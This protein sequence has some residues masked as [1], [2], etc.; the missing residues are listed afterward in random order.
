MVVAELFY[1]AEKSQRRDENLMRCKDFVS[2]FEVID[3]NLS[4]AEHYADIRATLE[5]LGMSIGGN[6]MV[7]ASVVRA[8]SGVLVTNNTR[9]FERV[10]SLLLEDW[11]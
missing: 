8:N 10:D 2:L 7:I 4:A 11:T 3:F 5:K 6:D 1:G 9:E